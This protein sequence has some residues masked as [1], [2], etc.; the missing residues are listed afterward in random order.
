MDLL[1][2]SFFLEVSIYLHVSF[3][4]HSKNGFID[5]TVFEIPL[6]INKSTFWP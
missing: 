4:E 3:L 2:N 5:N 6:K 1:I